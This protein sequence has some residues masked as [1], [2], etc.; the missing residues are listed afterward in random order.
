MKLVTKLVLAAAMVAAISGCI[1]ETGP[2]WHHG[3][4]GGHYY[5]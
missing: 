3:W 5:R 2:G 4:Y 1:V